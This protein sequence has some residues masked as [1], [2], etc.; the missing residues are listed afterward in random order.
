MDRGTL[1]QGKPVAGSCE[2]PIESP[3]FMKC[4]EL[5][6]KSW[7]TGI[8]LLVR[9]YTDGWLAGWLIGQLVKYIT[10]YTASPLPPPKKMFARYKLLR[11]ATFG[12]HSSPCEIPTVYGLIKIIRL[13]NSRTESSDQDE[14]HSFRDYEL[15]KD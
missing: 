14:H 2:H 4:G 10:G 13:K 9:S 12:S 11:T 1:V 15:F 6:T 8:E 7:S 5:S 3:G